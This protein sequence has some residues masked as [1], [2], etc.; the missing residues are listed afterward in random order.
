MRKLRRFTPF[1]GGAGPPPAGLPPRAARGLLPPP[2]VFRSAE[3]RSSLCPSAS[4]V[5]P[6]L[7]F[8]PP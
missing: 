4:G 8:E 6:P 5:P 2:A 1:G 3:P 7:S